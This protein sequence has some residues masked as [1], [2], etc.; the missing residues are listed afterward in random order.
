MAST[1]VEVAIAL[2][3]KDA[4]S[5]VLSN[6]TTKFQGLGAAAKVATAAFAI[7]TT[8]VVTVVGTLTA[9]AV[10]SAAAAGEV[11]KLKRETG[12][13]AVE[14]SKFKAIGDRLGLSVDD[15]SKSFG[16]FSKNIDN[17]AK[18]ISENHIA[19]VKA[20]D[21]HID[22]ERTLEGVAERFRTMPDGVE[23][24]S[25]AMELFGKSGKDML[26]FLNQ[27]KDGLKAL[28][29]EAERLGL[30]FDD[31]ALA[32][33]KRFSLSQKDMT[34]NIE[35]LKNKIGMAFLPVL[36]DASGALLSFATGALPIVTAG[37]DKFVGFIKGAV[38]VG[39]EIVD[40]FTHAKPE[41]GG[42]LASLIGKKQ[43]EDFMGLINDIRIQWQV[44][45][46]FH[47]RPAIE[48]A[49]ENIP[50]FWEIFKTA[51]GNFW[52]AVKPKLDELVRQLDGLKDKFEKLPP[53][54]QHWAEATAAGVVI[55][56]ATGLDDIIQGWASALGNF[57]G[58]GAGAVAALAALGIAVA[59]ALILFGVLVAAIGA[60]I[61]VGTHLDD[62]EASWTMLSLLFRLEFAKVQD[63][64]VEWWRFLLTGFS[65]MINGV[66]DLLN[67]IIEKMNNLPGVKI[68]LISHIGIDL[69][70]ADNTERTLNEIARTR[71]A[72]IYTT[73]IQ[74]TQT[75][76]QGGEQFG[77]ASGTP[78]VPFDMTAR[79]HKGEAI[80]PASQNRP[81]AL[82][83]VNITI[84]GDVVGLTKTELAEEIGRV[85]TQE[86]R[87]QG[88]A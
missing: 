57:V 7:A 72:M 68:P 24:T 51:V 17:N 58:G 71:S 4:A 11:A 30:V 31:K 28:G 76:R 77:F 66:I 45:W 64:F 16:I 82:G 1:A 86:R 2:T 26:P 15:L 36:A 53:A 44:L 22:F 29:D 47:I 43:A 63:F 27:G 34:E 67:G 80:I 69:P 50:R 48:W 54:V 21:G 14:A 62:L 8:A 85:F 60:V 65:N 13:T 25:L 19:V 88:L 12:L 74:R 46:I 83:G 5:S 81:G 38:T 73:I 20:K 49:Q 18:A 37:L 87:M 23:K 41:A 70:D 61:Y 59:S 35:G 39:K 40:V 78:Y 84:N 9:L 55:V 6:V 33:A 79:I 10:K 3:A 42:F 75:D 32:A 56:K 52:S